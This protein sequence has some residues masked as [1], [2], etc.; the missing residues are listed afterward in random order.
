MTVVAP[1]TGVVAAAVPVLVGLGLG[2]RP[3]ALAGGGIV[4]S[5]R[6]VLLVGGTL[7]GMVARMW[8]GAVGVGHTLVSFA[9]MAAAT[10][11]GAAIGMLFVAFSR[12]GD[13]GLWPLLTARIG[14]TPLLVSALA[15]SRRHADPGLAL[16]R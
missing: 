13:S 12:T 10:A 4:L 15:W 9:T 3:G 1:V 5:L 14:A 16:G 6:A 11:V 8:D 7:D 2:E